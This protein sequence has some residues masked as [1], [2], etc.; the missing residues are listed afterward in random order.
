[1]NLATIIGWHEINFKNGGK[2]GGFSAMAANGWVCG[3]DDHG[4]LDF[5]RQF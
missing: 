4:R 5:R 3:L 1:L 2:I